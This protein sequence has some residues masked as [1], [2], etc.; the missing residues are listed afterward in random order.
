MVE[1]INLA[2][3]RRDRNDN[4][5]VIQNVDDARVCYSKSV[6]PQGFCTHHFCKVIL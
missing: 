2:V 6:P 3:S 4:S 1:H 5:S